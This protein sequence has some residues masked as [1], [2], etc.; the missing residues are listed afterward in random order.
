M[1]EVGPE[2][3]SAPPRS[4][5]RAPAPDSCK[6][7]QKKPCHCSALFLSLLFH[8][9]LLFLLLLLFILLIIPCQALP[10]LMLLIPRKPWC[11]IRA[12]KALGG[13]KRRDSTFTSLPNTREDGCLLPSTA[14]PSHRNSLHPSPLPS[15]M[16][17]EP[18]KGF[19][20]LRK[21]W[22]HPG[23]LNHT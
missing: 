11:S 15:L 3:P 1:E 13:E 18:Q 14:C 20:F 17:P 2:S 7:K 6:K 9:I 12:R 4:L 21:V 16:F 5:S 22:A 19:Y 8:S 10:F 23:S